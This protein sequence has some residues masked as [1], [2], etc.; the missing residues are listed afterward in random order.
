ML[1]QGDNIVAIPGTKKIK[2]LE[3]NVGA[4]KIHLSSGELAE[5]RQII[6]SIEITGERYDDNLIKVRNLIII[7]K[8]L[9][10]SFKEIKSQLI[11]TTF[12]TFTKKTQFLNI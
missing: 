5:I 2:Y 12:F 8:T 3:E 1:L 9:I 6:N 4:A 7:Y 10:F 11:L